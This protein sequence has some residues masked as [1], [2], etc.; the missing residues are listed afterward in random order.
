MLGFVRVAR[1]LFMGKQPNFAYILAL[2]P[3]SIYQAGLSQC[4]KFAEE[5]KEKKLLPPCERYGLAR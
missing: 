4:R 1:Q 2:Y 5:Q 3:F